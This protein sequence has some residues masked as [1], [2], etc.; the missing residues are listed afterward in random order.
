VSFVSSHRK[1]I[2]E[3]ISFINE[4]KLIYIDPAKPL[5]VRRTPA[6]MEGG[7][8]GASISAPGPF[9]RNAIPI[10]MYRRLPAIHLKKPKVF[11]VNTSLCFT[12]IKYA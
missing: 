8:A 11:F 1:Q 2:P 9:D 7:G 4:K 12:D 6:Y 10:I 3:L 5:V